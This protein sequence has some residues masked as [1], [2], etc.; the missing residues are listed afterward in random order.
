ML[1]SIVV[2]AF[3]EEGYLGVEAFRQETPNDAIEVAKILLS[4]G[5]ECDSTIKVEFEI[6]LT[7]GIGR[8]SAYLSCTASS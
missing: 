3:N 8:F 5:G 2:P 4:R 6:T 7:R 1:L